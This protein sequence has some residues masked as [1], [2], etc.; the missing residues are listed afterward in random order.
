[1]PTDLCLK[2]DIMV[3]PKLA[4]YDIQWKHL[5]VGLA[6]FTI[7]IMNHYTRKLLSIG[8]PLSHPLCFADLPLYA[9]LQRSRSC[10]K[11]SMS[12]EF[13]LM[14]LTPTLTKYLH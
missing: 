12:M 9:A 8:I 4:G 2:V 6:Y 14:R 7:N 10:A 3:S 1:M 11:R 5:Y 13:F